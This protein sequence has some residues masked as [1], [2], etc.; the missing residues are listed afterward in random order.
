MQ[1][2]NYTNPTIPLLIYFSIYLQK[3]AG[4]HA[5][6]YAQGYHANMVYQVAIRLGTSPNIKAEQDDPVGGQGSP[7]QV[8]EREGLFTTFLQSFLLT[9][10]NLST[11]FFPSNHALP[12]GASWKHSIAETSNSGNI[13]LDL[14]KEIQK[15]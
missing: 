7:K 6:W 12:A 15:K 13:E 5:F 1:N 14:I 2:D 10:Q 9:H 4:H 3:T 8:E 11:P